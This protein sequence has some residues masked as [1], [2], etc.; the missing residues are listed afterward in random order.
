MHYPYSRID[1]LAKTKVIANGGTVGHS[2]LDH[3][4]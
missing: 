2:D 4:K 3:R 1:Y